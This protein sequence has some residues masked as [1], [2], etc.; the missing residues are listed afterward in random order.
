MSSRISQ[1]IRSRRNQCSSAIVP[2]T[3]QRCTPRPEPCSVPRR[4]CPGR[5]GTGRWPARPSSPAGERRPRRHGRSRACPRHAARPAAVRAAAARLRP[6][7]TPA[8]A[9]NTSSPSRNP[10][11][12]AGSA[13]GSRCTGR[14]RS[15]TAPSGHPDAYA[16][17]DGTRA[18][19]PA[20]AARSAPTA[21]R[22]PPTAYVQSSPRLSH[23]PIRAAPTKPDTPSFPKRQQLIL[24]PVLNPCRDRRLMRVDHTGIE[25]SP[26][27]ASCRRHWGNAGT[28]A[29][30]LC[31][32]SSG[33]CGVGFVECR[34]FEHCVEDVT[35][36]S[37]E[38]E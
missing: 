9:A 2:S 8:D 33:A 30:P 27:S 14:T 6:H 11:P 20:R 34:V 4:S 12:P 38:A 19:S 25:P 28:G 22:Q 18:R 35:A 37:G 26:P 24:V 13:T 5:P 21:H 1:R 15:R 23:T 29:V 7:S 10:A 3:T 31:A 16:Q 32:L 17:E 36:A